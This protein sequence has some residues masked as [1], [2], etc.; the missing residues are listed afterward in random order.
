MRCTA[1]AKLPVA[2]SGGSRRIPMSFGK[3]RRCVL[4][5]AA[6]GGDRVR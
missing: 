2:L 5:S 6:A 1:L 4:S 3:S